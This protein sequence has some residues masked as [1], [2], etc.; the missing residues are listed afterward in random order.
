VG[1]PFLSQCQCAVLQWI[2]ETSLIVP[3][4]IPPP[5]QPLSLGPLYIGAWQ[6]LPQ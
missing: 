4:F 3:L 6:K 1:L 5:P 2:S